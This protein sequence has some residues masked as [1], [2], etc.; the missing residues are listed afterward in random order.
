VTERKRLREGGCRLAKWA[1][2]TACRTPGSGFWAAAR[3]S[4]IVRAC[5]ARRT[6]RYRDLRGSPASPHGR[7]AGSGELRW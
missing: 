7:A 5:A 6:C 2:V 4:P 1:R 3:R